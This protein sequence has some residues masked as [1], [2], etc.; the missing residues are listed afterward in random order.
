MGDTGGIG[1]SVYILK[2]LLGNLKWTS[3]NVRNIL[4]DQFAGID[5]GFVDLLEQERPEWLHPR[6][7]ESTVERNIDSAEGNGGEPT[8]KTDRLGLGFGLLDTFHDNIHKMGLDIFQ[9]HALHEGRNVY[10]LC[11]QVVEQVRE[12]VKCA[13]L[14]GS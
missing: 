5:S 1:E 8:L 9:R 3:S 13:K 10:I 2:V 12:A 6:T 11:F 4:A 14:R 7:E